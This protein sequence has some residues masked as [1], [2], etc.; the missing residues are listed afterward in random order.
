MKTFP[1]NPLPYFAAV[2]L[3][4]AGLSCTT[5]FAA[6]ST[7]PYGLEAAKA[8]IADM[9]T[10]DGL[11]VSLF[12][13][14]PMVQNPTNLDIDSKGRIWFTEAA[15]YRR[16]S[17]PPIRPEGDR[18]VMLEDTNGDGEADRETVFYQDP[19]MDSALGICVLG[20]QVIVSVA[21]HVFLLTDTDGDGKA[22]KRGLLLTGKAS[23]QHDHSLHAFTFGADGKLYFNFGNT[24]QE[25]RRP[26]GKLLELPLHGSV[27]K[28]LIEAN[29]EPILDLLGNPLQS[30][31]NPYR[32]GM[33]FRADFQDGKLSNFET[34]GHNFRN[35]YEVTVDSFGNLWQSDNDD[36][37][38]RGV[39][40]NYL[41]EHGNYGYRDEFTGSSWNTN[42]INLEADIQRRHWHQDDPGVVPNLLLT[43]SG[44]PTGILFN[45]GTL[46][47][48]AFTNQLIHCDA[49]PRVVRAYPTTPNG[50]GFNATVV[51]LLTSSDTWYRPA[52]VA[53]AP[54]GSLFVADWY[55]AGV[56]GHAMADNDPK[57]LRG[58]IYR[59]APVG[60]RYV[61]ASSDLATASGA[62]A[63]L[64]SPNR[65]TQFLAWQKLRSLGKSAQADLEK[66]FQSENPRMRARALSLLSRIPGNENRAL[67]A[68]LNDPHSG[69]VLAAIRLATGFAAAHQLDTS[70]LE[71]KPGLVQKLLSHSDPQVRRQLAISLHG[72]KQIAELWAELAMQ[73]DGKDRWYL[74]ALGI[75]AAGQEDACYAA[76]IK[77]GG[78]PRTAAGQDIIWRLRSANCAEPL[79]AA[80]TDAS[81]PDAEK[82]RLMRAFDFLPASQQKNSAL[83][84]V[85]THSK[86]P[87]ALAHHALLQLSGTESVNS[88]KVR[89]AIDAALEKS[90]GRIEFV[91][92]AAAFGLGNRSEQLF[93]ML[94]KISGTAEA[95]VALQLL[96]KNEKG[97]A[98][99]KTAFSGP[100]ALS[101]IDLLASIPAKTA[102]TKLAQM[103]HS[104]DEKIR[105]AAVRALARTQA[106][107][108]VLVELSVK[109]KFPVDLRSTASEALALVQFNDRD[110]KF[111]QELSTHF[112][113]P[114]SSQ[115]GA[116]PS[117]RELLKR[118]GDMERGKAVFARMESSCVTCHKIGTTGADFGPN[119]SEI[120]TKLGRDA[121]YDAILNPNNGISM[122]FETYQF[123]MRN[124]GSSFGILRSE[125]E[126]EIVVALPGGATQRLPKNEIKQREK[127]PHSMMPS[128]LG[129]ILG[130]QNL[131]DL[132][133]Y[134]ASCKAK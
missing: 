109:G 17:N 121:L 95:A 74:E 69:V 127:L 9:K 113:S 54:D 67:E 105:V 104:K 92:L 2:Q 4:F 90:V 48:P 77:R 62:V 66:L 6:P 63:A 49:G 39:R 10:A 125:T 40:I 129:Q 68:A 115:A 53:I 123:K 94:D 117:V 23:P 97:A 86:V 13:A 103:L 106:G 1:A 57:S 37:G 50:A 28:D 120:G 99:L 61:V 116:P 80:V 41:L 43:G 96:E 70:V 98:L 128:G 7:T 64:Q 33:V 93:D 18:V 108:E 89:E 11:A 107:A 55:D 82:P 35:N 88:P 118:T 5:A 91:Q 42:R 76:W 131:V 59:V 45:E 87:A 38:N 78:N 71:A 46:L 14:E 85:S 75:G 36:D 130:E 114:V 134:L 52:D 72:S 51:D 27:P 65:A 126:D 29:S 56:G 119:L 100:K 25:L 12:A 19:S 73:H 58:R 31:G 20:N 8:S 122:G 84:Q 102:Q 34:L 3:A 24:G 15:N 21:P 44:S 110:N 101:L 47:G 32:Q 79:A 26:T 133:E 81:T 132:V 16:W 60:S 22:D 83:L 111:K 124:G 30:S 112:P